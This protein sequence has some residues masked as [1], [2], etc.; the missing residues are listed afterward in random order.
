M[1]WQRCKASQLF[2]LALLADDDTIDALLKDLREK[3]DS[4][5]SAAYARARNNLGDLRELP[6]EVI[7]AIFSDHPELGD[8]SNAGSSK[9]VQNAPNG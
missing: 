9:S 3:Q 7:A 4:A 6:T 8:V 2:M 5:E 1:H